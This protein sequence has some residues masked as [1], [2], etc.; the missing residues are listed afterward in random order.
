MP[1]TADW[2]QYVFVRPPVI[3]TWMGQL[4]WLIT[5]CIY[6]QLYWL[7]TAMYLY[8][9]LQVWSSPV[10]KAVVFFFFFCRSQYV[11]LC[12]PMIPTCRGQFYLLST[13]CIYVPTYVSYLYWAVVLVDLNTQVVAHRS[14]VVRL[15]QVTQAVVLNHKLIQKLITILMCLVCPYL[16]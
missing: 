4:Y 9:L 1:T 7:I 13:V 3:L 15:G 5:V 10:Y 12:P 16:T 14:K 6:V 2:S 8:T 11:I